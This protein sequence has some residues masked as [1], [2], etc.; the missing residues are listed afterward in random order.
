MTSGIAV[1]SESNQLAALPLVSG[2][3]EFCLKPD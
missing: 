3:W 1:V 2:F